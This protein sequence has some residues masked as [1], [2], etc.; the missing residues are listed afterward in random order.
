MS[1]KRGKFEQLRKQAEALL[2]R[3]RTSTTDGDNEMAT[4]LH[5]LAVHQEELNLQNDE[6]RR[7]QQELEASRQE[8]TDLF[9]Y[10]PVSYF[11]IDQAGII[12]RANLTAVT[13]FKTTREALRGTP[14]VELIAFGERDVFYQFLRTLMGELTPQ[15]MEMWFD[16]GN[17]ASFFGKVEGVLV[18]E[19]AD[20]K[21]FRIS[22]TDLTERK[23]YQERLEAQIRLDESIMRQS[24]LQEII[25]LALSSLRQ[26]TGCKYAALLCFDWEN[27]ICKQ[28]IEGRA[29]ADQLHTQSAPLD[30]FEQLFDWDDGTSR[31]IIKRPD[32]LPETVRTQYPANIFIPV[33]AAET[34][35]GVI[36][37]GAP[38]VDDLHDMVSQFAQQAAIQLGIAIQQH[39][40]NANIQQYTTDL[41]SSVEERTAQL[42][43]SQQNEH[44]Q[45]LFAEGM[46]AIVKQ[47]NQSLDLNRVLELVLTNLED[48]IDYDGAQ[49]IILNTDELEPSET[50]ILCKGDLQPTAQPSP[51]D[52]SPDAYPVYLKMSRYREPIL[53]SQDAHKALTNRYAE[54]DIIQSYLGVPIQSGKKVLG[55][56]EL[57]ASTPNWFTGEHMAHLDAFAEQAAIA[58]K[59]ARSY[60]HGQELA[61]LEE[62]QRLAR[63]L[64]DAVSQLIFS[65]SIMAESLPNAIRKGN[66]D[67]AIDLAQNIKTMA[68]SAYA[69]MRLLLLELRP[70][71]LQQ[72]SLNKLLKQLVS[73]SQGRYATLQIDFEAASELPPL[74]PAAKN[75]FYRIAQE[76]LNN[77]G[78]HANATQATI[79]L[80]MQDSMLTMRVEDNG[81]G[82]D[83][84]T[85]YA[86][87]GLQIMQERAR[88]AEAT[89]EIMSTPGNGTQIILHHALSS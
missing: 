47:I 74:E 78:R 67:K 14:F 11:V 18:D 29:S 8:L 87:H 88:E 20:P 58:V 56:I 70:T 26:I 31:R 2:E 61:A 1:D 13:R 23:Q 76:A 64:H 72:V 5:E 45:R 65:L 7:T 39:E 84:S 48:I 9:D 86:G 33:Y 38:H 10:A 59:N 24:D 25:A 43:A 16:D 49:L 44:A 37:L 60:R 34:L 30:A 46:L 89:L 36:Q 40:M 77:I 53:I 54:D 3:N 81:I 83:T 66:M 35:K 28:Y 62:R 71:N 55:F 19:D 82:F 79:R 22:I 75:T 68:A 52:F 21:T 12:L 50:I 63:D 57:Y 69:E 32:F 85:R 17:S 6:L 15:T 80:Q 51:E 4:L 73:A 42:Q 27:K 41:E